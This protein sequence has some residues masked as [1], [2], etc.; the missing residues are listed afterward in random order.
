MLAVVLSVWCAV[1]NAVEVDAPAPN[2]LG[3]TPTGKP[4][5]YYRDSVGQVTVLLFWATWCPY[6]SALM[7]HLQKV[8][9]RFAAADVRFFALDVWE[10]GDPVEYLAER[11]Y[12]FEL[13]LD[14]TPIAARYGVKGTP[15][16]LV[17][18]RNRHV[19]WIRSS[20]MSEGDVAASVAATIE[21]LLTETEKPA[22]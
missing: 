6:C 1:A 7:P 10:D 17:V 22:T 15:G 20:G 3:N 5:D 12:T 9:D 16:L 18:D 2:W 19:R 14:A 11:G 8:A 13:I 21:S 4:I